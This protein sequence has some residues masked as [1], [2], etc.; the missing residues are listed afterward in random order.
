MC[1]GQSRASLEGRRGG[2]QLCGTRPSRVRGT[3]GPR[4]GMQEGGGGLWRVLLRHRA[5]EKR[6]GRGSR[7]TSGPSSPSV[8][9]RVLPAGRTAVKALHH[10]LAGTAGTLQAS[11]RVSRRLEGELRDEGQRRTLGLCELQEVIDEELLIWLALSVLDNALHE[12]CVDGRRALRRASEWVDEDERVRGSGH[13]WRVWS[14]QVSLPGAPAGPASPS[15]RVVAVHSSSSL[16]RPRRPRSHRSTCSG[17]GCSLP[18]TR[19]GHSLAAPGPP[20]PRPRARRSSPALPSPPESPAPHPD[21]QR[22]SSSCA[23]WAALET[24]ACHGSRTDPPLPARSMRPRSPS[25]R[26]ALTAVTALA[27]R[28][29]VSAAA[30]GRVE[31]SH[32]D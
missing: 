28:A 29:L 21:S 16:S 22:A 9:L 8:T 12:L 5:W 30:P 1:V 25:V 31:M 6:R 32:S 24:D 23:G 7:G 19:P 20:P 18:G 4:D 26:P 15:R 3:R 13:R 27:R 2:G 10:L 11:E 17:P 14:S